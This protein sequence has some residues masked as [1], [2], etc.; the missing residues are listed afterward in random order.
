MA[1]GGEEI[2][3]FP[4]PPPRPS[5]LVRIPSE[6]VTGG[7]AEVRL[8]EA[9]GRLERAFTD[10][11]YGRLGYYSAPDGFVLVSRMEQ[12]RDDGTPRELPVRWSADIAPPRLFGL[13]DYLRALFSANPGRYRVIAFVVTTRAIRPDAEP[14]TREQAAEWLDAG[15]DALPAPLA[16]QSYTPAHR[17]TA[18]VYE[19]V[20]P[21]SRVAAEQVRPSRTLARTHLE[22]AGL[23]AALEAPR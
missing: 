14:A 8:G 15:A 18:L 7:R 4:W 12:I 11:G 5:D 2:A 22:R 16:A 17:T 6:L 1:N 9:A 10:A 3:R 19:F 13:S 23:W 20:R 21:S